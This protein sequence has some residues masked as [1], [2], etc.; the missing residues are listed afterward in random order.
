YPCP[1]LCLHDALPIC[2]PHPIEDANAQISLMTGM[3]AAQ[4]M[5]EHG[6]GIL[7]TM[8]PAEQTAVDRFRRQSEALGHPWP[9]QQSYGEH[10]RR[11][12][13]HTSELQSRFDL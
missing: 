8:P 10:L 12:E 3:A 1:T 11:S 7:R 9:E 2:H 6:A 13:E 5:L 4:L